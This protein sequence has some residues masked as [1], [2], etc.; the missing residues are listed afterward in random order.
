MFAS[1]L[2]W[3]PIHRQHIFALAKIKICVV[4]DMHRIDMSLT[5]YYSSFIPFLERRSSNLSCAHDAKPSIKSEMVEYFQRF[6]SAP[7]LINGF[8][9]LCCYCIFESFFQIHVFAWCFFLSLHLVCLCYCFFFWSALKNGIH[10]N[11]K[12]HV[13]PQNE[14]NIVMFNFVYTQS[15]F[16]RKTL[17][18]FWSNGMN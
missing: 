17:H 18:W 7:S 16:Q 13:L 15:E 11:V 2:I 5:N 6:C 9:Q 14:L 3:I 1:L 8:V 12:M 4:I 10:L